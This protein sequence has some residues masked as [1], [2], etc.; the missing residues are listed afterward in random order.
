MLEKD[1]DG[2]LMMLNGAS[3]LPSEHLARNPNKVHVLPLEITFSV[4]QGDTLHIKAQS[5]PSY[6]MCRNISVDI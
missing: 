5:V 2:C 1:K 6:L 4:W 3:R